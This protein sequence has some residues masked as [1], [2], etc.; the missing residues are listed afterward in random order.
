MLMLFH[1]SYSPTSFGQIREIVIPIM[2]SPRDTNVQ[3]VVQIFDLGC[4]KHAVLNTPML[5]CSLKKIV[6]SPEVPLAHSLTR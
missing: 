5:S 3:V 2:G 6:L 1:G 4:S